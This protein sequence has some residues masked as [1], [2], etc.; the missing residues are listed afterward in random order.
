MHRLLIPLLLTACS[1]ANAD[2][3][4]NASGIASRDGHAEKLAVDHA[5]AVAV[6]EKDGADFTKALEI[7]NQSDRPRSIK[8][9]QGGM[10]V[11]NAFEG[12]VK[13]RPTEDAMGGIILLERASLADGEAG[14]VAPQW[15]RIVFERGKGEPVQMIVPDKIVADCWRKQENGG[16]GDPRACIRLRKDRAKASN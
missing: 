13:R 4:T 16:E 12:R 10:M 9:L 3:Q 7:L 8:D 2:S 6:N 5:I 15:L 11:L 14:N 1:G